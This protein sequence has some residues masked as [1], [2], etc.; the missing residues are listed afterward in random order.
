MVFIEPELLD[1]HFTPTKIINGHSAELPARASQATSVR[2]LYYVRGSTVVSIFFLHTRSRGRVGHLH[3]KITT[4]KRTKDSPVLSY[5]L[6]HRAAPRRAAHPRR[7]TTTTTT[8][9]TNHQR[10]DQS[11]HSRS[12]DDNHQR[13]DQS[14]QPQPPAEGARGE[15]QEEEEDHDGA[16][17]LGLVRRHALGPRHHRRRSEPSAVYSHDTDLLIDVRLQ[18][19]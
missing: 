16:A 10:R 12:D 14:Q 1:Q 8:T 3:K 2:T 6:L 9:T 11:Q 17:R 13:R 7:T 19:R 18:L 15:P 4:R 5:S